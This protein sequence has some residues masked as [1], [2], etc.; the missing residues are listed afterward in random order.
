MKKI[1]FAILLTVFLSS[2][3]HTTI[4]T[5]STTE[6]E[7]TSQKTENKYMENK[8]VLFVVVPNFRDGELVITENV[9][10]AKGALIYYASLQKGDIVGN[11][12]T[13]VE[14]EYAVEEVDP[15]DFDVVIFVGG[16]GMTRELDNIELQNLSKK[17][18]E[19]GKLT[20]AIC[21]APAMM[22]KAGLL[23]GKKATVF[24]TG[25][26]FLIENGVN[27]TGNTVEKDGSIITADG[28]ES[29]TAFANE[30]INYF[31]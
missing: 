8:K 13:T 20:T 24:P 27:Y 4:K 22:A 9:L 7:P 30:I 12:G 29:S 21:I 28:P 19:S 25:K 5:E 2:C 6:K 16:P 3:S 1:L 10:T 31:K 15:S 11:E 26:G 23:T 14:A 18:Y 17:F